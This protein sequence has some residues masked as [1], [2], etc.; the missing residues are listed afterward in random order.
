M[1]AATG[2][3]VLGGRILFAAFF[4]PVAGVGHLRRS[5]MMEQYSRGAGLPVPSIAG[6]PTGIWLIVAALSI[7]LG[8]WPDIGAL[9]I[10]AFLVPAALYFH[11]FWAIEDQTQKMTQRQFFWRNAI[12]LGAAAMVFGTFVALGP[13]LRFS[14]TAPLFDF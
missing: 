11:R 1:S 2:V 7:A 5:K 3:I 13:A 4:G 9:M 12:G 8:V 14:V 6:W 10:A